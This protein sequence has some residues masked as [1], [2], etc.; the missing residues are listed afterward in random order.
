[1]TRIVG[2]VLAATLLAG[3]DASASPTIV[4]APAAPVAFGPPERVALES[5]LSMRDQLK[6]G[7]STLVVESTHP[8]QD[9]GHVVRLG[10]RVKGVPVDAGVVT[11]R[12]DASRRVLRVQSSAVP[13]GEVDV[14][15]ALSGS[16]ALAIARGAVRAPLPEQPSGRGRLVVTRT[17]RLAWQ[18]RVSVAVPT[19]A[20]LVTVD[21]RTGTVL[22]VRDLAKHNRRAN[23]FARMMSPT[24]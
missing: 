10:Q 14:T 4:H 21:A 1:M 20:P 3:G 11:V 16:E 8:T 24:E 5:A 17:G 7:R 6:L 22:A 13:V 18:V 12:L 2:A 9:G 19:S 15:P 23:V